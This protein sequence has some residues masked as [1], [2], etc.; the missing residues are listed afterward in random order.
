M[1]DNF[2]ITLPSNVGHTFKD[3]TIANFTTKLA[4]RLEMTGNWEVGLVE[5]SYT[6]SWYNVPD[7][8]LIKVRYFE[9]ST[10]KI[11]N[12]K[13]VLPAG[14]YDTIDQLISILNNEVMHQIRRTHEIAALSETPQ[15][16]VNKKT[17]IVTLKYGLD[18]YNRRIFPELPEDL[19]L[20]LG[21][22]KNAMDE[23]S[24]SELIQYSLDLNPIDPKIR[25][26]FL[27]QDPSKNDKL[28]L[29]VGTRP[30]EIA[31][32]FHS[33]FVYTD[34]VKPSFVGDSYTQ[35]LRLVQIPSDAR[36]GQQVLITYP[37]TYYVPLLTHDFETIEIHIKDDTGASIP[38]EFGRSIIV[39]H[40]R[41]RL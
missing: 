26:S 3:N 33:L 15:F 36:F 6:M 37:N 25:P 41:K 32:G 38:F 35:L 4:S 12:S 11:L 40:F 5:M 19:C 20:M 34:I 23:Y 14:R 2:Y 39:L 7:D 10:P 13:I 18:A 28:M 9:Q 16:S 8:L 21:F 17:R 31:A 22:D 29:F 24:G 30:Y 27:P 1:E